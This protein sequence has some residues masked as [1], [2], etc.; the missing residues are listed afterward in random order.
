MLH[1]YPDKGA[2]LPSEEEIARETAKIRV[3]R[4]EAKRDSYYKPRELHG[5]PH[6][7]TVRV[8]RPGKIRGC[9]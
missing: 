2:Y 3:A 9:S 7:T 8:V 1:N 4:L 6:Q 5:S